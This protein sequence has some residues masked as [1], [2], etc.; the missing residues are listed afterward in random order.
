MDWDN[1]HA[2]LSG[3]LHDKFIEEVVGSGTAYYRPAHL[4]QNRSAYQLNNPDHE[5][6]SRPSY[7]ICVKLAGP[8]VVRIRLPRWVSVRVVFS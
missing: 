2:S 6:K 7:F 4:A 8:A 3:Y 1:H 5:R